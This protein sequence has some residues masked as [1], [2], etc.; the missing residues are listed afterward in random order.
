MTLHVETH[1]VFPVRSDGENMSTDQSCAGC[2]QKLTSLSPAGG[3]L[4][5]MWRLAL[6]EDERAADPAADWTALPCPKR[7]AHFEV[8]TGKD[9]LPSE[10][11]RGG[12][13]ITYRA[14]DTILHSVVALKVI[15]GL[16]AHHPAARTHFLREARAAAQLRHPNVAIVF[17]YGEQ[18]GEC[19]YVMELVEGETL[20]EWVRCNGPLPVGK[21]L[22]VG[23]QVARALAAAE[24]QGIV[25]RDLKPS[26][27]MLVEGC[28]EEDGV[29]VK[30]IDFGLAKAIASTEQ[31][32]GQVAFVGTPIYAS[33]EQ[34]T[35]ASEGAPVDARAD[36]Y[37]LGCTLWFALCGQAPFAG[38]TLEEVRIAQIAAPLPLAQLAAAGVPESVTGLLGSMLAADPRDRPQSAHELLRRLRR[39]QENGAPARSS[40]PAKRRQRPWL[41]L[42]SGALVMLLTVAL[43]LM[44]SETPAPSSAERSIAVLPFENLSPDPADAFFTTGVQDEIT[45]DLERVTALKVVGGESTR[46]YVAGGRDSALIRR[47]L[48]VEHLLGGSV[49]RRGEQIQVSVR[50][51]ELR[52]PT[53]VWSKQYVRRLSDVFAL[54]GEVTRDIAAQMQT[55]LS[56]AEKAAINRPPTNDLAAY[57]LYLRAIRQPTL[58]N[59][60]A[61]M[62]RLMAERIPLMEE[63]IR[64]DPK[65]V[66]AYC[67]LAGMH[68]MLYR[69][70]STASPEES[71]VDHRTLAEVALQ[72]ARR[73]LPDAGEVH[74]AQAEHFFCIGDDEQARIEADLAR[75]TL[76]SAGQVE[77]VAGAVAQNQGRWEDAVRA[78]RRAI[79]LDPLQPTCRFNLAQIY[80]MLRRYDEYDATMAEL[81]ASESNDDT[82]FVHRLLRALGRLEGRA[83]TTSLRE[84]LVSVT[85]GA[86]PGHKFEDQFGIVLALCEHDAAAVTRIVNA[87][88]QPSFQVNGFVLP[89][90]WFSALAARMRGDDS[91]VRAAFVAA[92]ADV[93]KSVERNPGD[94][95]ELSILAMIDAGLGHVED[96]V[97]EARRACELLPPDKSRVSA[98]VIRSHLAV[99]YAWTNQPELALA[100]LE[101][102]ASQP[103]GSALLAQLTYGDL[104]L[105]PIW[106]SLRSNPRFQALV[107]RLAPSTEASWQPAG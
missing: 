86:D 58:V 63:A 66:E 71:V 12:M 101:T 19:F 82:A 85:P 89:K 10:L 100:E 18:D 52:R 48:G 33:P 81:I 47:Q 4:K 38:R 64:R 31:G 97:S 87:T 51:T 68:D 5:C 95:Q 59:D 21:A 77:F 25:H 91:E 30:V 106:D 98:P 75:R 20:E 50:L 44:T 32:A 107:R 41:W 2:G 102:L 29:M 16:V 103:A 17:H 49:Q 9:G 35:S 45:A 70:R 104:C 53:S 22:D 23:W 11:G 37:S 36:I 28:R 7:Y 54:Q 27:L 80:R 55:A 92:R 57:D 40:E 69:I 96:A 94:G 83:E 72:N 99:V 79:T 42:A 76:P 34:F 74:L 88:S 84:A 14:L 6:L 26:N 67:D 90:A 93:E 61:A 15:S 8:T 65:F 73:L 24:A 56:A 60:S 1:E 3:C 105:D 62:R 43:F 39:C 78:L 46:A 13:G